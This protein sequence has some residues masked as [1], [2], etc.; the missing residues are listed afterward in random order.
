MNSTSQQ[1]D[2]FY[3]LTRGITQRMPR[4]F[5]ELSV[6]LDSRSYRS[7][8]STGDLRIDNVSTVLS[9]LG[10]S[11]G[12]TGPQT[13]PLDYGPRPSARMILEEAKYWTAINQYIE[14]FI[15][16]TETRKSTSSSPT[17]RPPTSSTAMSALENTATSS[18]T[19][20]TRWGRPVATRDAERRRTG[21][22]KYG[23][24][25]SAQLKLREAAIQMQLSRCGTP[26]KSASTRELMSG[27]LFHSATLSPGCHICLTELGCRAW[28]TLET[29]ERLFDLLW[30]A[31]AYQCTDSTFLRSGRK[32]A[33]LLDSID[34]FMIRWMRSLKKGWHLLWSGPSTQ[35]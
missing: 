29:R 19:G 1:S 30:L 35:S 32:L 3:D 18:D 4:T 8:P 17:T 22:S 15:S 2:T 27:P 28:Q 16:I 24:S 6:L 12:A 11:P 33:D 20:A 26:S 10:P 14:D 25:A 5:G 9:E 31:Q 7:R 13:D 21:Y 23:Q 34:G